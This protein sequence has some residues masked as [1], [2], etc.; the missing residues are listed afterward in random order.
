MA[1]GL[2][3]ALL[4]ESCLAL[5]NVQV[6]EV[7]PLAR[8]WGAVRAVIISQPRVGRSKLDVKILKQAVPELFDLESPWEGLECVAIDAPHSATYEQE[9]ELRALTGV[10]L[11]PCLEDVFFMKC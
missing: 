9:K 6:S 10:P 11:R 4:L 3:K 7:P 8:A 1:L 5:R 2:S